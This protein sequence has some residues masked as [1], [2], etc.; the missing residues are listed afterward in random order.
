MCVSRAVLPHH[1]HPPSVVVIV[2]R[3][4]SCPSTGLACLHGSGP[5]PVLWL[6]TIDLFQETLA[7]GRPEIKEGVGRWERRVILLGSLFDLVLKVIFLSLCGSYMDLECVEIFRKIRKNAK[8]L[9]L[10]RH[11][12]HFSLVYTCEEQFLSMEHCGWNASYQIRKLNWDFEI[13]TSTRLLPDHSRNL[14]LL[15]F[16]L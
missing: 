6:S 2:E 5:P 8:S 13:G 4:T 15:S 7:A 10:T 1:N 9:I 12:T 16:L 14:L 11:L 3:L